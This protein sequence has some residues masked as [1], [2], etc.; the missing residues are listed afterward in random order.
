MSYI[1][2]LNSM[3]SQR[4]QKE[5]LT[6]LTQPLDLPQ[7]SV[8]SVGSESDFRD[9]KK[10]FATWGA[11]VR[12]AHTCSPPPDFC[13]RHWHD[14]CQ[15]ADWLLSNFGQLAARRGWSSADLFGLWPDKPHW[16]GIAD[17]LRG[18]RSLL[19]YA[20]CAVWRHWD[21]TERY[22]RGAY[23]NLRPFWDHSADAE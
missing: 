11:H 20:N 19:M 21:V 5:Q 2:K 15:D 18:S 12:N 6:S 23:P 8:L 4:W 16:G 9:W 1:D 3:I 7:V 17:R 13:P 14:L 10:S 22:N